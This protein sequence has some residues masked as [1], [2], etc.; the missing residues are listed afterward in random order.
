MLIIFFIRACGSVLLRPRQGTL[1]DTTD[2]LARWAYSELTSSRFRDRYNNSVSSELAE[3]A[4]SGVAFDALDAHARQE[5]ARAAEATREAGLVEAVLGHSQFRYELWSKG[6]LAQ[7]HAVASYFPDADDH[8]HPYLE[9]YRSPAA[10]QADGNPD[11]NDARHVLGGIARAPYVPATEAII[12]AMPFPGVLV[13][14]YLRSAVFMRD[15]SPLDIL[16][17]WVGQ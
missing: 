12:V 17:A 15:G 4:G 7:T 16:P 14:G 9:F 11:A 13:D 8:N 10:S 6:R 1:I 3:Q 2:L 5:L